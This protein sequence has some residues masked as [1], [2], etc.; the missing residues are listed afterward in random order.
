MVRTIE[1]ARMVTME[2]ARIR[3]S[4]TIYEDLALRD[5]AARLFELVEASAEAELDIDFSGVRTMSRAFAHEY[6]TRRR[7]SRKTVR[8][9]NVPEAVRLMFEAVSGPPRP[10]KEIS[11]G[12]RGRRSG[13][14]C[15]RA[16]VPSMSDGG[17]EDDRE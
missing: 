1:L 15:P 10:A 2:H 17:G 5:S 8:E 16:T 11:A 6:L 13:E 14:D 4:E 3:V 7:A 12:R 9:T